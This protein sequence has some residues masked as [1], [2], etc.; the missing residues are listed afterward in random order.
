MQLPVGLGEGQPDPSIFWLELQGRLQ[1]RFR[2]RKIVLVERSQTI[3]EIALE[4]PGEENQEKPNHGNR[5]GSRGGRDSRV[6]SKL[7]SQFELEVALR[8]GSRTRDLAEIAV[9]AQGFGILQVVSGNTVLRRIRKVERFGAELESLVFRNREIFEHREI[10]SARRWTGLALQPEIAARKR[11][12]NGDRG[13][14]EPLR[15]IAPGGR[16]GIGVAACHHVRTARAPHALASVVAKRVRHARMQRQQ[17]VDMPVPDD[18]IEPAAHAAAERLA[19]AKGDFIN[20]AGGKVVP[21]VP[22][23]ARIL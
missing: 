1:L 20:E 18:L 17:A 10:K 16:R 2:K 22:G 21:D 8:A 3:A 12:G 14:V 5:C 23:S 4:L 7:E 9:A 15:G 6:S 19:L 11:R 13:D